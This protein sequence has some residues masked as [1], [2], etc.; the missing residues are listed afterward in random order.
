ME[1]KVIVI[2]LLLTEIFLRQKRHR[3][4]HVLLRY[5]K[6]GQAQ[7]VPNDKDNFHVAIEK[8]L[9]TKHSQI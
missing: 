9:E 2:Q 3:L 5:K 6:G 4:Y 8:L 7:F 1:F